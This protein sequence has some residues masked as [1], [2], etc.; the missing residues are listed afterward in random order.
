M[1]KVFH[2][3]RSH[4][5]NIKHETV[6]RQKEMDKHNINVTV[7]LSRLD[8]R[9]NSLKELSGAGTGSQGGGGVTFPGGVQETC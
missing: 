2:I 4:N 9:K 8:I 3:Q 5:F 7:V 1:Q 6:S